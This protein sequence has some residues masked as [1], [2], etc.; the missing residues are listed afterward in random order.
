[1]P[2]DVSKVITAL[3]VKGGV[4]AISAIAILSAV[5]FGVM[6]LKK[7]QSILG[8][9][10]IVRHMLVSELERTKKDLDKIKE[11]IKELKV[12]L[13]NERTKNYKYGHWFNEIKLIA[14]QSKCVALE[15]WLK[16]VSIN[17]GE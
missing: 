9:A 17:L 5:W 15:Q 2:V 8:D 3:L 6:V 12:K 14:M 16:D 7:H 1:M 11:E 13:D 10:D 4:Y